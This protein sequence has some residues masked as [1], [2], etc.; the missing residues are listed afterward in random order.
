MSSQ[1]VQHAITFLEDPK[2]K[3]GASVAD[4]IK[5]LR[6]KG[7]SDKEI[8]EAAKSVGD[9]GVVDEVKEKIE[10]TIPDKI[11][12]LEELATLKGEKGKP[13]CLSCKGIVYKVDPEFYGSGKAYSVFSGADCSRHL[14]KVKVGSAELN[15]HWTTHLTDT[16]VTT[17]DDWEEKY[18]KKYE[19]LGKIDVAQLKESKKSTKK[20]TKY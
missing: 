12:T 19:I 14:A 3:K 17:L 2:V 15:Q 18:Q 5:F 13:L 11:F 4:K 9:K 16:Q 8:E 7:L 1:A 10:V 6:G 20:N